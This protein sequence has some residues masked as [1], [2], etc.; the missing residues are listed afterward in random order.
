MRAFGSA[1]KEVEFSCIYRQWL[2][3]YLTISAHALL[4]FSLRARF[5]D[6]IIPAAPKLV[7]MKRV[8]LSYVLAQR[9]KNML[10]GCCFR[11]A[12]ALA[13]IK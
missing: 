9:T 10:K 7:V 3:T 6:S 12:R 11:D 13:D 4:A 8:S 1:R 2:G 5:L